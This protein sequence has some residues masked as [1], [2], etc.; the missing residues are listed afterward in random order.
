[1][2][3]VINKQSGLEDCS[4]TLSL[5]CL[6]A[7]EINLFIEK[8]GLGFYEK[9]AKNVFD[10]RVR[11]MFLRLAEEERD[12]IQVLQT[13]INFLKPAISGRVKAESRVDALVNDELKEKIFPAS[14]SGVVEKYKT[15]VEALEYGIESEKRSINILS[16][17][18]E[19]EKKLDVKTVFLHLIAEEKQHLAL[20][21]DLRK[22]FDPF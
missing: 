3:K 20:L 17:L 8:E 16:Q 15:D 19:N 5:K 2:D 1:M 9:A 4:R 22:K 21:E 11:D 14:D 12:H 13:K 10:R 18:L 7:I 6:D